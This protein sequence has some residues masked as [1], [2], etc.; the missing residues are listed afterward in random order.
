MERHFD[1]DFCSG[2][3]NCVRFCPKGI[4]ELNKKRTKIMMSDPESCIF[5]RSC[6][7]MCTRGAFWF[8]E[9]GTMPEDIRIM[10]REKLP[11]HAGCQF[12]IMAHML[13][14]AVINTG[15]KERVKLFCSDKAEAQLDVDLEGVEA[16]YFVEAAVKYKEEHPERIVIIFYSDPKQQPHEDAKRLFPKLQ[17][18][19]ITLIHC[20][21]YFEQTDRYQ[22][23]NFPSEHLA[24]QLETAYAARGNMTSVAMTLKTEY[25]IEEAL[26]CQAEG[27]GLSVVEII[28]PCFFR[29]ENRPEEP[30]CYETRNIIHEWFGKYVVPEFSPG[31]LKDHG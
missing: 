11:D 3:G 7:T 22:G 13:A 17:G 31:N 21:G 8:S 16:P 12:G 24:E 18:H 10:G 23:V 25:M 30:V 2:C 27:T 28:F 19:N 26:R 9:D 4:L 14:R 5:C 1:S 29:L 20:L 15:L 6:E